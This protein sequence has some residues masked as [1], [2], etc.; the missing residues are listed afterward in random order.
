MTVSLKTFSVLQWSISLPSFSVRT[1]SDRLLDQVRQ[2]IREHGAADLAAV[3]ANRV[4]QIVQRKDRLLA[5]GTRRLRRI[6]DPLHD[7]RT[8][9]PGKPRQV[10]K[11]PTGDLSLRLREIEC[12][13]EGDV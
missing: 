1:A 7:D 5:V 12:V 4:D 11:E 3:L 10:S 6:Q 2:P 9:R 13:K 8:K